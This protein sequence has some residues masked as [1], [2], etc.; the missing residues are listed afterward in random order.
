MKSTTWY[1]LRDDFNLCISATYLP[2]SSRSWP[3]L[4]QPSNFFE[5]YSNYVMVVSSALGDAALWFGSVEAKLRQLNQHI[6]TESHNKV[7]SARIWPQPFDK[8]EG[9]VQ[10]QMWFFGIRMVVGQSPENIQNPLIYFSD[11]CVRDISKERFIKKNFLFN[12]KLLK[13]WVISRL[14]PRKKTTP[15]KASHPL[16]NN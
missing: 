3:D 15:I 7:V 14:L 1:F 8:Q 10:K 16:V 5:E 6:L 11:L 9:N 12:T 2:L 13:G 4:F